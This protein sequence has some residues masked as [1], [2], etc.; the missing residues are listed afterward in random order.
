MGWIRFLSIMLVKIRRKKMKR[1]KSKKLFKPGTLV[2]IQGTSCVFM[3]LGLKSACELDSFNGFDISNMKP[4]TR[5][6]GKARLATKKECERY[7]MAMKKMVK[8]RI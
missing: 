3:S 5:C 7:W 6:D 4:V 1:R 8:N 2:T